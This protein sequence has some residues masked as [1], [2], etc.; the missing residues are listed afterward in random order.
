[1][2]GTDATRLMKAFGLTQLAT[3]N[4][5]LRHTVAAY[6][7]DQ[8][9]SESL[10]NIHMTHNAAATFPYRNSSS[11]SLTALEELHRKIELF[12]YATGL[13]HDATVS[14]RAA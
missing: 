3:K 5:R 10:F 7:F 12:L 11:F 2:R 14:R 13:P 9:V 1:M 4:N 6:L 8:G